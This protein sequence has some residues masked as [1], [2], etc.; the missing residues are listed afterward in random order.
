MKVT[1]FLNGWEIEEDGR[2]INSE[3]IKSKKIGKLAIL[4]AEKEKKHIDLA[5]QE[6]QDRITFF[7]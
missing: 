2:I 6:A 3:L 5:I 1:K 7:K 4:I